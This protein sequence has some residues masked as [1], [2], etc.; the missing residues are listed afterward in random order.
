VLKGISES[1]KC[2]VTGSSSGML[3]FSDV[4]RLYAELGMRSTQIRGQSPWFYSKAIMMCILFSSE[5]MK[6]SVTLIDSFE[7]L[8]T[9]FDI[10]KTFGRKISI[11]LWSDN[12]IGSLS[13]II[14]N[15]HLKVLTS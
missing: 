4:R 10:F 14:S 9:I 12:L 7:H 6:L 13:R 5:G 11:V 15:N 8:M 3:T 2:V 1:C